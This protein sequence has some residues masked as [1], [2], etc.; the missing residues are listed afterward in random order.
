MSISTVYEDDKVITV[1][2]IQ[3]VNTGHM[4]IFPKTHAAQ[5]TDLHPD[6]GAHMF[7][8]AMKVSDALR[9]SGI[10]CEGVNLFLAD[11][12]AAGQEIFHVHL[13]VFPRFDG[14]G[15][16]LRFD[17]NY[18]IL[19]KRDELDETANEIRDALLQMNEK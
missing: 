1:M 12:E 9:I 16:G 6:L 4:L 19:P 18:F 11:G 3:P 13:H 7:K 10:R 14:D 8:V 5:L 17:E 15:F 2:D